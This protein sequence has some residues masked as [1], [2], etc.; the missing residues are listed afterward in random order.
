MRLAIDLSAGDTDA[1]FALDALV[2]ESLV[3]FIVRTNPSWLPHV[4]HHASGVPVDSA[5]PFP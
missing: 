1:L 4:R 5:P 2:R 3:A